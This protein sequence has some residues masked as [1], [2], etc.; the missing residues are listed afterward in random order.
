MLD[1]SMR[2]VGQ[3]FKESDRYYCN[4]DIVKLESQS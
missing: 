1:K 4:S 2:V 3:K